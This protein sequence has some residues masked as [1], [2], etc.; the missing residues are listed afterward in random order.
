VKGNGGLGLT[1]FRKRHTSAW[2]RVDTVPI[3]VWQAA[4]GLGFFLLWHVASVVAGV[5]WI[6]SP[7]LVAGKLAGWLASGEIYSHLLTTIA[8]IAAGMAIGVP[9]A[10]IAG[11]VL[12]QVPTLSRLLR[13]LILVLYSIPLIALVPLFI[14]LFGIDLQPKIVLVAV[15]VFFLIFFNT[16]SG[17]EK[18]DPDLISLMHIMGSLP[19]EVFLKVVAPACAAWIMSGI[20]IALPYA[21]VAAVTA[22]MLASRAGLGFVIKQAAAQVNMSSFYAAIVLVTALGV[23]LNQLAM[24]LDIWVLRWRHVSG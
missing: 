1:H 8:E 5:E 13:P 17:S 18:V 20:Q 10:V 23:V 15:V 3:F 16:L 12:G 4:V 24:K 22:E 11:L 2:W 21:L 6:S 7:A 14:M 19:R 9:L